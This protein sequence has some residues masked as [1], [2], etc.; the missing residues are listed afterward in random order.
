MTKGR[1]EAGKA[2]RNPL[3]GAAVLKALLRRR[4]GD[5]WKKTQSLYEGILRDLELSDEQVEQYLADHA[6]EVEE[7]IRGHG[8][9][10]S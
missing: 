1:G 2:R 6:E 8:R 9:R 4:A 7:A 3:L 10:G 5:E